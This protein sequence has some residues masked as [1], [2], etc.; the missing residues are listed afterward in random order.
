VEE[1]QR[2]YP[3]CERAEKKKANQVGG[4][5]WNRL[6]GNS[7]N[8]TRPQTRRPV[9]TLYSQRSAEGRARCIGM[10]GATATRTMTP[11]DCE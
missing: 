2:R 8:F 11:G 10:T 4:S 1:Y 6:G 7:E 5:P 9:C 3:I